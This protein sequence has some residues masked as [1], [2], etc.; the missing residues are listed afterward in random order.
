M[1][2]SP[3]LA[4][5]QVVAGAFLALTLLLLGFYVSKHPRWPLLLIVVAFSLVYANVVPLVFDETGHAR[6]V[7]EVGK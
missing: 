7:L 6:K 2:R 4:A 3:L 1:R 5:P